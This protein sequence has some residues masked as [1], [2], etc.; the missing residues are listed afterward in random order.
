MDFKKVILYAALFMVSL[1]L[2]QAWQKDYPPKN[3]ATSSS[4]SQAT[5]AAINVPSVGIKQPSKAKE[6][7]VTNEQSIKN[8]PAELIHVH[9]DVMDVAIDLVGGNVVSAKLL[10][11]PQASNT[12]NHPVQ[13]FSENPASYYVAQSG[14]MGNNGPDTSSGQAYY[15]SPKT[16]F[17]LEPGKNELE[18]PLVW[19]KDG[20]IVNKI[21]KFHRDDYAVNLLYNINNHSTKVWTGQLYM[22]LKRRNVPQEGGGMFAISSYNGANVFCFK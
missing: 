14:L 2:W 12:P 11:Y 18:V 8:I 19:Q 6:A 15:S 3:I 17:E 16:Q 5:N 21:Y 1:S 4:P 7:P 13:L 20:I 10:K 9:T 22:Q